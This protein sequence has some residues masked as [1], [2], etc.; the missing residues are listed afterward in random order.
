MRLPP[1][2]GIGSA[3]SALWLQL[4]STTF[5]HPNPVHR[6]LSGIALHRNLFNQRAMVGQ[7]LFSRSVIIAVLEL[8]T[9]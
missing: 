2:K 7:Q 6:R 4:T 3:S 9:K 5:C 1:S 8:E